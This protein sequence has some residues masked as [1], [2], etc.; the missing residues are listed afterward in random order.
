MTAHNWITLCCAIFL[1]AYSIPKSKRKHFLVIAAFLASC[2][3]DAFLANRNHQE[4]RFAAGIAG[5]SI[6]HFMLFFHA[7]KQGKNW[8]WETVVILG[9]AYTTFYAFALLPA[10]HSKVI[11]LA[12]AIYTLLSIATLATAV[13]MKSAC[14]TKSFYIVGI[15]LLVFSDT[16]IAL[17][18][19][20]HWTRANPLIIPTYVLSHLSILLSCLLEPRKSERML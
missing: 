4:A 3:G 12:V 8:N 1:T 16:L 7:W 9:S 2:I 17:Q 19:F 13:G 10:M 5:F 15:A 11:S 18:E 6:A 20:L 14:A